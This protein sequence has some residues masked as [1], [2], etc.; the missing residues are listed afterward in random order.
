MRRGLDDHLAAMHLVREQRGE[1]SHRA[2]GQEQR[3]VLAREL[4]RH[5]FELEHGGIV[6]ARRIAQRRRG[7]GRHHG[8]RGQG[9]GVAAKVMDRHLAAIVGAAYAQR[10]RKVLESLFKKLHE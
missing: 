1:I 2:R 7:D 9:D 6:T 8:R 3:I 10:K 5:T 4:A